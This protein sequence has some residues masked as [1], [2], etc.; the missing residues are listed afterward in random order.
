V[1]ACVHLCVCVCVRVCVCVCARACVCMWFGEGT[2]LHDDAGLC[3]C[4]GYS[5]ARHCARWLF[6]EVIE[7]I[8]VCVCACVRV[9]V[10]HSSLSPVAAV[11][12]DNSN[13]CFRSI[14]GVDAGLSLCPSRHAADRSSESHDLLRFGTS[15]LLVLW[16]WAWLGM[17]LRWI[18]GTTVVGR[19]GDFGGSFK[20]WNALDDFLQVFFAH[21]RSEVLS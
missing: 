1:C 6:H 16:I 12:H 5:C 17:R 21:L 10:C 18:G 11:T 15:P 9:C 3:Q 2:N 13:T 14:A 19:G 8:Y 4:S 20:Y 7:A